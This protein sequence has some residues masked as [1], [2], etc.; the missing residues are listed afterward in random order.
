[1]NWLFDL[2]NTR[3]KWACY[4]AGALAERGA[5]TH[6][7][8]GFDHALD[9]VLERL[10][11]ARN[12]W[13]ASVATEHLAARVTALCARHGVACH[14]LRT[15][16][17][18]AGVRIA[19]PEPGQLGV[20]RWLALLA[21]HARGPGPWLVAS[22][23]T[24]LTVDALDRDGR[25]L[26]GVISA[27]EALMREG[28]AARV[29]HLPALGG[30]GCGFADN[31]LDALASG[32]HAAALGLIEHCHA[33]AHERLGCAP[34]IL[35][36]G[37]GAQSLSIDLRIEHQLAPDLVLEGITVWLANANTIAR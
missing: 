15:A 27:S 36:A 22:A 30:E 18:V 2:G 5:L 16:A 11:R 23:G 6:D 7:H 17:E 35:L 1:M 13:L 8:G 10:P 4:S 14:R 37:G 32:A 20:D 19:Y 3:L 21:A 25:H 28:L 33:L 31:T 34:R 29:P 12:A 9:A 26:G 24:A